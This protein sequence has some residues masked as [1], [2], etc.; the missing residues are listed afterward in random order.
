LFARAFHELSNAGGEFVS[1]NVAET[2][3]AL[4]SDMLF[5]HRRGAFTG[6]DRKRHGLLH[7]AERGSLFL[8]E[9]G[10]LSPALQVKLLRTLQEG[11]FFPVGSDAPRKT[12]AR[13]IAATSTSPEVLQEQGALRADLFYRLSAHEITIPPLRERPE[14]IVPLLEHFLSAA[15]EDLG[16]RVPGY[17][18]ELVAMLETYDFPGNARELK[19]M[20]YDAVATH[21]SGVLSITRFRR[22]LARGRSGNAGRRPDVP[23]W[24]SGDDPIRCLEQGSALPHLKEAERWLVEAA[25]RRA[26]GSQAAAAA[27]LGISRQ[28][29]NRRLRRTGDSSKRK[30]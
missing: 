6:A 29:L 10:D 5:G 2:D 17:P 22:T 30:S 9:I 23:V 15:A 20:V 12:T 26:Q 19:S 1:V 8:D 24:D 16:R 11:E 21:R 3:P 4:F 14:D 7:R 27:M 25:I 28:A 13:I 18:R